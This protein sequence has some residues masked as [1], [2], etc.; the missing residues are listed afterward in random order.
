[1][2]FKNK[3]VTLNKL[4]ESDSEIVFEFGDNNIT[5]FKNPLGPLYHRNGDRDDLSIKI[6]GF[7][8]ILNTLTIENSCMTMKFKNG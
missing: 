8:K 6:N 5:F 1:M 4:S 2:K 3:I 7:L